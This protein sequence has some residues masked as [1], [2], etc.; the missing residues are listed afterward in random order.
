MSSDPRFKV[1]VNLDGKLFGAEPDARLKRPLLWIQSDGSQTSEYTVGRDRL[2]GGLQG[3]GT[4]VTIGGSA[5]MSFSDNPSYWTSPGRSVIGG[6]AGVGSKSLGDM[7][8]MT[9]D[10]ISS[11]VGPAL[12]ARHERS[13]N[14]VLGRHAAIHAQRRIAPRVSDLPVAS[15]TGGPRADR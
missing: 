2:L 9:G 7:T 12:G 8:A 11:F 14:E 5:H 13:V 6:V 10:M 1:G 15:R 3:G 4:V